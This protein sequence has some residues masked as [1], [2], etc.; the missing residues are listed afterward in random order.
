MC[1]GW[2]RDKALVP[3][4]N[5]GG[6]LLFANRGAAIVT[7]DFTPARTRLEYLAARVPQR[8]DR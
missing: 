5:Q 4:G 6:A 1:G 3:E 8:N 2:T 7:C